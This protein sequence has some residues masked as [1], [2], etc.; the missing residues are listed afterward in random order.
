[1]VGQLEYM[2]AC[3]CCV[4]KGDLDTHVGILSVYDIKTTWLSPMS[5]TVV[6]TQQKP[7]WKTV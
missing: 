4:H 2:S 5:V 7:L 1:M 6:R 3:V